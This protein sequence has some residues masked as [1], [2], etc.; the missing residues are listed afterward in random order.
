MKW[1]KRGNPW[2]ENERPA[3]IQKWGKARCRL[4]NQE[5]NNVPKDCAT[6]AVAQCLLAMGIEVDIDK[7]FAYL[8]EWELDRTKSSANLL[9]CVRLGYISDYEIDFTFESCMEYIKKQPVILGLRE[10]A[11]NDCKDGSDFLSIGDE[12]I[13][14]HAVCATGH[15][16]AWF[17][18]SYSY[19]MDTR[20]SIGRCKMWDEKLKQMFKDGK[21][22]RYVPV[23]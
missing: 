6:Y 15:K 5:E 23:K 8:D 12:G 18:D 19:L 16:N 20:P 1:L 10:C 22:V 4:L 7:I 3:L 2:D 9:A 13:G 14:P 21:A 17:G 11:D